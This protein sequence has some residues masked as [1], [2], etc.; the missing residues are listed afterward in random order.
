MLNPILL[1]G[2]DSTLLTIRRMLLQSDGYRT[3][4]ASN[5]D[6]VRR[7][8]TEQ[9]IPLF[10]LCHTLGAE[11]RDTA[12]NLAY[13]LRPGMKNLILT[14]HQSPPELS[15]QDATLSALEGPRGLLNATA[16]YMRPE[17]PVH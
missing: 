4:A 6:E 7:I 5:L 17:I 15:S 3:H 8:L 1:Y 14:S 13:A 9:P 11:E 2:N 12:L 16:C 10:V